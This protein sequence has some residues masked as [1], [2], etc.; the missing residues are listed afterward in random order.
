MA[1]ASLGGSLDGPFLTSGSSPVA[2]YSNW[3]HSWASVSYSVK[4]GC[5]CQ[6]PH[7]TGTSS[8]LGS[9]L[10][11]EKGSGFRR[12]FLVGGGRL[13]P[14]QADCGLSGQ[15]RHKAPLCASIGI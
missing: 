9:S 7:V 15:T 3:G 4:W 1:A 14:P 8:G 6:R 2:V 5:L 11:N 12:G 13:C 10:Q